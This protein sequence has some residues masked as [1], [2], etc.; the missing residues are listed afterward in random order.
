M[1]PEE[2]KA[3]LA[4]DFGR[5][6]HKAACAYCH[7]LFWAVRAENGHW[8]IKGNGSAFFLDCGKGPFLVTAAHVYEDYV[9]DLG[10]ENGKVFGS[11]GSVPFRMEERLLACLGQKT[12]DIATF[13]VKKEEVT[14]SGEER[15][16]RWTE[17]LAT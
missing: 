15:S 6:L 1:V 12:L 2:A 9:S 11:L 8:K 4:G 13:A 16:R 5:E 17:E 14:D 3:L 7:P 10:K